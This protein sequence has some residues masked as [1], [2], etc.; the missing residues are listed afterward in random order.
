MSVSLVSG[1]GKLSECLNATKARD[2]ASLILKGEN[3]HPSKELVDPLLELVSLVRHIKET[4]C[5]CSI[6]IKRSYSVHAIITNLKVS[7]N[8]CGT[9]R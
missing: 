8:W 2:L 9:D 4:V 1:T 7:V 6:L 3:P 5:N